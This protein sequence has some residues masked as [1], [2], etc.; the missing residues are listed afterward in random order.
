VNSFARYLPDG[1][2]LGPDEFARRHCVVRTLVWIH[3]PLLSSIGIVNGYSAGHVAADVWVIVVLGLVATYARARQVQTIAASLGLLAGSA[4][5]IHL[6]GGAIEAHF[7]IFVILVFVALYQD[8]KALATTI[9]FTVVH[10]VGVSL[11]A[12]DGAFDHAAAQAKPVLWAL[13]HAVFVVGEVAGILL[14]WKVAEDARAEARVSADLALAEA[15]ERRLADEARLAVEREQARAE[16][17][18]TE[19]VRRTVEAAHAEAARL[20]ATTDSLHGQIGATASGMEEL[21]ASVVEISRSVHDANS[22]ARRAVEASVVTDGIMGRLASASGEIATIVDMISGIASQTNL[23]ALNATIEAA[24]AGEAGKGFAVVATE[25]KELANQTSSATGDISSRVGLIQGASG[26]ATGAIDEI[27]QVIDGIS[28]S[29][30]MI[31]AAV[32]E[33]S[34]TTSEMSRVFGA[35]AAETEQVSAAAA[36]LVEL[37]ES[38]ANGG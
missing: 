36:R 29:Q 37:V 32:E 4:I 10:H 3:L 5:L 25:V 2:A 11:I 1:R 31:V 15:E 20:R 17:V 22:I 38:V 13:I 14:L 24:R 18:R 35:L 33:Q 8:W 7:H 28:S 23:L 26:E 12:P 19:V 34:A 27:R 21:S 6:T 16:T 30:M 9:V